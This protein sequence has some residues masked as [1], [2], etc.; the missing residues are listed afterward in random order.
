MLG[1]PN[2]SSS[3]GG[4]YYTVTFESNGG[5]VVADQKVREGNTIIRPTN[6]TKTDVAFG[7]WY[8]DSELD[9]VW[10]FSNDIPT[11]AMT[12]YAKWVEARTFHCIDLRN[13]NWY[14]VESGLLATGTYC[15]IYAETS[16]SVLETTAAAVASG[17]DKKIHHQII[18]AFGEPEDVDDNGKTII[19]LLDILDGYDGSGGYVAG[20]FQSLRMFLAE[21][22]N[23]AD[24][25]FMDVDPLEAGSEDFYKTLAHEFQHLIN[26]SQTYLVDGKEQDIWINEGLSSAAEYVYRG[27]VDQ[28]HIDW[29]NA[30]PY[31]PIAQGNDFFVWDGYW[32][33]EDPNTVL[34]DYATV[35]LFFQWLRIH[36]TNGMGIY[37]EILASDDRDFQAVTSAAARR[38]DSS[39]SDWAALLESWHLANILC[40][41]SGDY[42]YKGKINVA[43]GGF[44]SSDNYEWLFSPGE[45]ILSQM[46]ESGRNTPPSGSGSHIVYMGIDIDPTVIDKISPYSGIASFVFNGN[47]DISGADETGYVA[48]ISTKATSNILRS[49]AVKNSLPTSWRMDVQTQLDGNLTEF[50]RKLINGRSA[51]SSIDKK[52]LRK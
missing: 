11:G 24:M 9:T 52:G 27:K 28:D 29:Y 22:S 40:E 14:E 48:N 36:A 12:L 4:T 31:G 47:S 32:E 17:Y 20:F 13:G 41:S 6:P 25:L 2:P 19:L 23:E 1:C 26:F 15:L 16:A 38:I 33:N 8:A 18:D 7:G 39:Y 42:G 45:G 30:D 43:M 50:S 44:A 10:D 51:F 37:K 35:N 21:H 49:V 34:D 46:P 3:S 5:T